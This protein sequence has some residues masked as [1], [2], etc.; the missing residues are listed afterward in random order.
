MEW[1]ERQNKAIVERN[2][3][4][5]VAAAAGS[6]KTAVLVERIKKLLIEENRSILGMLIVTFTQAAASE[7]KE[8]IYKSLSAAAKDESLS[9]EKKRFLKRQINDLGR[10][11]IS[12]FHKFALEVIRDYYQVIGLKPGLKVLDEA[13]SGILKNEAMEELFADRFEA[14]DADFLHFLDCYC[15]VKSLDSAKEMI[16]GYHEFLSSLP[17]PEDYLEKAENGFS[18][19]SDFTKIIADKAASELCLAREYL[20]KDRDLLLAEGSSRNACPILAAKV[21]EEIS[22]LDGIQELYIKGDSERFLSEIMAFSFARMASTKAEK[23]DYDLI[24][25]E[26]DTLRKFAKKHLLDFA[27]TWGNA[28]AKL[29]ETEQQAMLPYIRILSSLTRDFDRRYAKKKLGRS[30]VDF[31]DIEHFAIKILA[32]EKVRAEYRGRFEFIFVDE[33]QDSNLVQEELIR[34]VAGE[35]NVFMVGDIKQS[36]YKF[37]LAEPEIF[38]SKYKSYK[39]GERADSEV[40]DLNS[41]FRSKAGII[42]KVN[43]IFSGV[44]TA[45]SCNIVYDDDAA[46]KEGAPYTGPYIYQ[47]E[48]YL[49]DAAVDDDDPS[50]WDDLKNDELEARLA[51]GIIKK[52][53]GKTIAGKNGERPLKYSDMVILLRSGKNKG[54]IYYKA[55]NDAGIPVF[56]DRGEGYFDTFEIKLFMSM[57]KLIDNGRNDIELIS[58]MLNPIFGFNEAELAA[59]RVFSN[60]NGSGKTA[61]CD[62]LSAFS[63]DGDEPLRAKC[64][65]FENKISALRVK[66]QY[67]PLGDFIWELMTASGFSD[68]CAA[69]P[70][71]EQRLANL[72]A[73]AGKAESFENENAGGLYGFISYVD[74]ITKRGLKIDTGQ[75][76]TLSETA[77]CVRIMTIHKS[78]GLEFPFVLMAGLGASIAGPP[79][80]STAV[81]H[82]T[83]GPGMRIV[84]PKTRVY[85]DPCSMMLIK[86]I[87]KDE[88]LAESIRLLYVAMTRPQDILIMTAVSRRVDSEMA[89]AELRI[90]SDVHTAGSYLSLI[91]PFMKKETS[92]VKRI[93]AGHLANTEIPGAAEI[94]DGL[95]K[96]FETALSEEQKKEI[97]E[98]L[99]F[100]YSAELADTKKKY[101]VSR[102]ALE[103]D[104]HSEITLRVPDYIAGKRRLSA[105]EK[106]T[107]YHTVMEH[108]PFTAEGKS[109]AEIKEFIRGLA[110][111]N[112]LS[113]AEADCVDENR[114]A[115]FFRSEIGQRAL[116]AKE[117]HRE[118]SFILRTDHD[119]RKVVVQGT[120]DCW[121]VED[122]KCVLLDY[123]SNYVDYENRE[124]AILRLKETYL[125]QLALYREAL[126]K[127]SG[128]EVL[129]GVLY[130]FALGKEIKVN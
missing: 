56:L 71:G 59:I 106:G 84:N 100:S 98:R 73:L 2:K 22:A 72:R 124:E 87:K 13:L 110:A 55:L 103:A 27:K 99:S 91:L 24:K 104:D 41:N 114:I 34:S 25:E 77:D 32:D 108:I 88:E 60:R 76:K 18:D 78:K 67:S 23:P 79:E 128:M 21:T 51:A 120:I 37:R 62:A 115:A 17:Y 96:G 111:S 3:N 14:D 57:L 83:L 113:E 80:K 66:A 9:E 19:P 53:H 74:A 61:F 102:L 36:I 15:S 105:A 47:P 58:C 45:E 33:Y 75:V 69:L 95:E 35:N 49:A 64:L 118:S 30:S 20:E 26:S 68:Y 65:D 94:F 39:S 85:N 123:K 101:S 40:I 46:L 116:R 7:M 130:L 109:A 6:G 44:M 63:E 4:L 86:N 125:P 82:K 89:E 12:T 54:E 97:R 122:G 129:E 42:N 5:L 8:K 11:N 1:T 28:D 127:I 92:I 119:G 117:L 81:Y 112:V 50:P 121:F 43:E 90:P 29:F 93:D 48:L 107:A 31:S 38:A 126:E 52:Y 10:A 70:G 16:L